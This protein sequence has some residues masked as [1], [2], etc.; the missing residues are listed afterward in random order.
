MLS[1]NLIRIYEQTHYCFNNTILRIMQPSK[2]ARTLLE[3]LSPKGAVFITAWNPL[4]KEATDT[5]NRRANI[6]LKEE[7]TK[8]GLNIVDGYG[9]SP[10][11][12]WRED[13][14]CAYPVDKNTSLSLCRHFKQNAVVYISPDGL[15]ELLLNPDF[16]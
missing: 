12:Q 16:F 9:K 10:D 5:E 8:Q 13:S 7:L 3:S 11:G 15:P 14:F 1:P 4:G 2:D 6:E